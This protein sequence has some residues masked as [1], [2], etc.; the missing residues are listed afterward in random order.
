M[1]K[2][3]WTLEKYCVHPYIPTK[4][5]VI[6]RSHCKQRV[7]FAVFKALRGDD[8]YKCVSLAVFLVYF[9]SSRGLTNN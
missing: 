9:S 8:I 2:A 7:I 3:M 6:A 1:G 4:N 5:I